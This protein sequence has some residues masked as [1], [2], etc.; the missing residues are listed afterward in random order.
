MRVLETVV[1]LVPVVMGCSRPPSSCKIKQIHPPHMSIVCPAI[2]KECCAAVNANDEGKPA[3][4]AEVTTCDR[5]D[6]VSLYTCYKPT[7]KKTGLKFCNK[8]PAASQDA[9]G[10]GICSVPMP[11]GKG[12]ANVPGVSGTCCSAVNALIPLVDTK[13]Q[14]SKK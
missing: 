7:L 1:A 8:E 5:N 13:A 6:Q 10:D 2:S 14:P 3:W 4:M 9:D 12:K 11:M